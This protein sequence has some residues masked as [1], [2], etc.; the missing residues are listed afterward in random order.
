M[1]TDADKQLLLEG[2]T[3][4][5]IPLD[6]T[7]VTKLDKY[8]DLLIE[9]NR[10]MNLTRVP[11]EEMVSR[12]FLDSLVLASV[13]QPAAGTKLADVGTGAGLPGLPLAIA[14]PSIRVTL[15]EATLKKAKFLTDVVSELQLPNVNVIH[16]RAEEISRMPQHSHA[17]GVVTARAV[18]PMSKL[19]GWL[20]PLVDRRGFCAA[21][22]S[23]DARREI[24]EAAE[25]IAKAG[26][27]VDRLAE[28]T[29]PG[30]ETQR[31]IAFIVSAPVPRHVKS[32]TAAG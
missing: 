17:Y 9:A 4:L 26:G 25:E 18:A 31:L 1:L 6:D 21:Y 24:E 12:H 28:V 20:L 2:C 14:F 32:S 23:A 15:I 16:A 8:G 13:W 11:V 3:T 30:C 27:R 7:A 10:V 19:A 5:G 29:V 22:K